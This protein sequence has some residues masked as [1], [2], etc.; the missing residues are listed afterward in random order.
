MSALSDLIEGGMDKRDAVAKLY[1]DSRSIEQN[2]QLN[3]TSTKQ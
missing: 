2:K 1:K 3:T